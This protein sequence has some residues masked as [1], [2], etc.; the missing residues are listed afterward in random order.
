MSAIKLTSI[1][2][3]WPFL[4]LRYIGSKRNKKCNFCYAAMS[5]MMSQILKF[6]DFTET[7]KYEILSFL[8]IKKLIKII[9]GYSVA[10]SQRN[11]AKDFI[12]I[13]FLNFQYHSR[14]DDI[15]KYTAKSSRKNCSAWRICKVLFHSTLSSMKT[16]CD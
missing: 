4:L 12:I 8:R 13:S 11:I 3:I 2:Y 1:Y 6:V 14:W 9:K 5:M 16:L 15:C 10:K 7:Q